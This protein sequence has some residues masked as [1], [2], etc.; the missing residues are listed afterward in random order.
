MSQADVEAVRGLNVP[1][2]GKNLV[3]VIREHVNRLRGAQFRLDAVRAVMEGDPAFKHL[4]PDIEWDTRVPGLAA[5]ACGAR[6]LALWW[7]EWVEAWESYVYRGIEYRDLGDWVLMP[8][9]LQV[10]S[11][12]GVDVELRIFQLYQVRDGKVAICRIFLSEHGALA[13]VEG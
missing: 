9:E 5:I 4:H 1:Y 12:G 10:R 3:P 7:A 11:K 8:A 2:E 13:A 6:E